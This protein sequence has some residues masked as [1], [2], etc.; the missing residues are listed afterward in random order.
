MKLSVFFP[1]ITILAWLLLFSAPGMPS[2]M[3]E[4]P[5]NAKIAHAG[6]RKLTGT[7]LTFYT[8]AAGEEIDRLPGVFDQAFPQWCRYFGIDPD[9]NADWHITG[10]LMK[11]KTKFASA[12]LLPDNLP[13]FEHGYS[14]GHRLWLYDQ[15]T[16]FYRRELLLHEGTHAFMFTMFE[17]AGPPWY[18]EGLAEL[19]GTHRLEEGRL[20]LGC[21]PRSREES[22]GWG[23]VRT[24]QDAVAAR[25]AMRIKAVVELPYEANLQTKTYAWQWAVATL[26]D[27]HPRYQKRFRQLLRWVREPDFNKRFYRLFEP[28]WQH[29]CEE[30]Q[31]MVM[32]MEYGY[33]VERVAVDFTPGKP[34]G[35]NPSADDTKALK[36]VAIAAD[37]GWQNTGLRLDAEKT[38]RLSASGR[39]QVAKK[40]KIWWCEPNG[41]S[42]RY[43]QGRPLGI[44][45]AAV[46]P[47]H[48]KPDSLTALANPTAIG[49]GA[50]L[51]PDESG[52]LFLKINDSAGELDDNA[53][54]LKVEIRRE[55][56][57]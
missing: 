49:L 20:E 3:A 21:M 1:L 55:D 31:L 13:P 50:T 6:I 5:D 33:D 40:P 47:D 19:L 2:S 27:R 48:P 14:I 18:M 52:T 36:T 46:R 15:P 17:S 22:A 29:L 10:C 56:E 30:W 16:D 28:N 4:T 34:W 37:R 32:G 39:Y 57:K 42:I 11:D 51:T 45:L 53:G 12:G 44:L 43:Y 38:Y 8:D 9:K 35:N 24:I 54:E 26:L 23:R 7:H 25:K 41:V